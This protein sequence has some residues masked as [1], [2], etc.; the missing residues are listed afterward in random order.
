M[1]NIKINEAESIFE[2]LWN[3][4]EPGTHKYCSIVEWRIDTKGMAKRIAN[5]FSAVQFEMDP[6][7]EGCAWPFSMERD[8]DLDIR[9]YDRIMMKATL[10]PRI[11][12]RMICRIDG[13]DEEIMSSV[14][15][16]ISKSETAIENRKPTLGAEPGVGLLVGEVA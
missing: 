2:I 11:K 12:F 15:T 8:C 9:G 10:S 1:R 4:G 6:W 13:N 5:E 3:H 14:G 16:G 7:K